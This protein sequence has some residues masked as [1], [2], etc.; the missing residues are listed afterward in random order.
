V[1]DPLGTPSAGAPLRCSANVAMLFPGRALPAALDAAARAGFHTVELLDPY[2]LDPDRLARELTARDLTLDLFNLPM[3]DFAAGERGLAGDPDRRHAFRWGVDA[4]VRVAEATGARKVNALAGSRVPGRGLEE[5]L[6]CLVDNLGLAADRLG[7][8]GVRVVTEL[9]NPTEIPGF[10]LAS[11]DRVREVLARLGGRVGFQLDIY[12]L[13]RTQGELMRTITAL[14][15]ITGHVQAA[16]APERSEPGSGEINLRNVLR[17]L[18][19]TG[20]HDL[21]GL[22]YTPSP[23]CTDPFA[24]IEAFGLVRG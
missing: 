19:A 6:D 15:P 2:T 14:A 4:A 9:L 17:T 16:D 20:Y 10:L 8:A 5:Q 21:V 18:A 12:H 23:G 24:W 13:Q 11:V 7:P 22:E 3:G 1:S